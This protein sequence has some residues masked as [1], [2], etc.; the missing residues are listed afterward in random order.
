MLQNDT[1]TI[2]EQ[3]AYIQDLLRDIRRLEQENEE[4][5]R[6]IEAYQLQIQYMEDSE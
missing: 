4:L 5:E 1:E 3:N 2:N 6:R